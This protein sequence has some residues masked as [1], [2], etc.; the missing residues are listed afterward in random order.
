MSAWFRK[1]NLNDA[2]PVAEHGAGFPA[3]GKGTQQREMLLLGATRCS[4]A[5]WMNKWSSWVLWRGGLHLK[6]VH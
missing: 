1:L 4:L 3:A 6:S 5:E 2:C